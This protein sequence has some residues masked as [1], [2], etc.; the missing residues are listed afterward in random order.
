MTDTN[1]NF[2]E[3]QSCQTTVK[4]DRIA[5]NPKMYAEI[6]QPSNF[7]HHDQQLNYVSIIPI[8]MAISNYAFCLACGALERITKYRLKIWKEYRYINLPSVW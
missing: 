4:W 7:L 5:Y 2:Y 3:S 8:Y 6:V 1:T